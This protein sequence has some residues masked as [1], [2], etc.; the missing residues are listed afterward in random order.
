MIL[1]R[2][3]RFSLLLALTLSVSAQAVWSSPKTDYEEGCKSYEAKDY[4]T[5]KAKLTKASQAQPKHWA[6]HYQL[7]NTL[8]QLKQFAEAKVAYNKCL[9]TKPPAEIADRCMKAISFLTTAETQAVQAAKQPPSAAP[10]AEPEKKV[11]T[12]AEPP[13][14]ETREQAKVREEKE[15]VEKVLE[16]KRKLI[17]N[18]AQ[19]RAKRIRE[20]AETRIKEEKENYNDW[21]FNPEEGQVKSRFPAEREQEMKNEAEEKAKRVIEEAERRAASLK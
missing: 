14:P 7:A 20:D 11:E 8:V 9:G 12:P 21:A 3:S 4:E 10:P 17:L 6:S 2:T 19:A 1:S 18:D 15:R 5:A 13:P 16:G